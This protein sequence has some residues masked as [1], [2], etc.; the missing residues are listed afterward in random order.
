ASRP[1]SYI[2]RQ[3]WAGTIPALPIFNRRIAVCWAG[4]KKLDLPIQT[5]AVTNH[6]PTKN[7]KRHLPKNALRRAIPALARVGRLSLLSP[8]L[9]RQLAL[10]RP[11]Q[12]VAPALDRNYIFM[13]PAC[14]AKRFAKRRYV[15]SK[16]APFDKIRVPYLLKQFV[17]FKQSSSIFGKN[18]RNI[19]DFA[20]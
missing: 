3:I 6:T 20:R 5:D 9:R 15:A 2:G 7:A 8:R 4:V 10:Q 19:K 12:T 16:I 13:I 14:I 11:R 18:K 1:A 17:F